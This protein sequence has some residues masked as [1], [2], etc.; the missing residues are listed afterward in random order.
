MHFLNAKVSFLYLEAVRH[1]LSEPDV[2]LL[3]D[4][5]ASVPALLRYGGLRW[6]DAG[7]S[8]LHVA[9]NLDGIQGRALVG[10]HPVETLQEQAYRD[11]YV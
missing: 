11:K 7:L 3:S 8:S 4:V 2:L 1:G 9:E 6:V 10:V 5:L